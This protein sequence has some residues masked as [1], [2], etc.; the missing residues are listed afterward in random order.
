MQRVSDVG[1]SIPL[2]KNEKNS[3][4]RARSSPESNKQ[5]LLFNKQHI[6]IVDYY[7][8]YLRR[9][10]CSLRSTLFTVHYYL[11]SYVRCTNLILVEYYSRAR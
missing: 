9:R 2:R 1:R 8:T 11:S 4:N 10:G 5:L 3:E 7:I 6:I